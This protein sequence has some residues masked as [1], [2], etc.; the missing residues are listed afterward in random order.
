[1]TCKLHIKML[2]IVTKFRIHVSSHIC[3]TCMSIW[4]RNLKGN[5]AKMNNYFQHYELSCSSTKPQ[6][7]NQFRIVHV[8]ICNMGAC[9]F[10]MYTWICRMMYSFDKVFFYS[11][12]AFRVEFGYISVA[13]Q[14]VNYTSLYIWLSSL[15]YGHPPSKKKKIGED[16]CVLLMIIMLL[17]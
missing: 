1:M 15:C 17:V 3:S 16:G 4:N 7:V 5:T 10:Q 12:K 2:L 13:L 8:Y 6:G 14:K 9:M 11:L